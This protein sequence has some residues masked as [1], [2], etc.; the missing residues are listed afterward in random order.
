M[1][2][3]EDHLVYFRFLGRAIGRALFDGHTIKG[4]MVE[5]IYKHLL[6]W[7]IT[8]ADLKTHDGNYYESL[9]KLMTVENV[10]D[11]GLTFTTT[12]EILGIH[13]EKELVEV[14]SE[15]AVTN[16]NFPD[17]LEAILK[18]RLFNRTL[19]QLRELLLGFFDVVP[20]AAL[21]VF[22]AKELESVLCGL[23]VIDFAPDQTTG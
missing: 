21:T 17:Y 7:P 18:Y 8:M 5:M 2:R 22:D 13:E 10:S 19:P 23:P 16:E 11:M 6:G 9:Q 4:I 3:P 20:E 1:S 12:E 14:G 15:I